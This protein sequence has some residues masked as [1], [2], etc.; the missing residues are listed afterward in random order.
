MG[1]GDLEDI[2]HN[3]GIRHNPAV[4][5][6]PGDDAA[7]YEIGG[8]RLIKTV[9]LITPVVNDPFTYGAISVCN[10]LSDVYAMGGRPFAALAIVGFSNCDYET[11]VL[12]E[13]LKG[14]L[15]ILDI[16][17]VSLVG[18]HCIDDRELKFGLSVTGVLSTNKILTVSGARAGDVLIITKPIGL[19]IITTALKGGKIADDDIA[20]AVKWMLTLNDEASV[21]ALNSGASA[22]TDVTGFGL[23]GHGYNMVKDSGLDLVINYPSVPVIERV[24]ELIDMGMVAAGAYNNLSYIKDK[25]DFSDSI[26]NEQKLVLTDP[27]TSGGLLIALSEES[28]CHFNG[29]FYA[30]IGRFQKGKGRIIVTGSNYH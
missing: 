28:L 16:A 14:A 5:I 2:V 26:S 10:S 21:R 12:K 30:P 27:Q 19:G 29:M 7:V 24:F 17:G 9:D 8:L 20:H 13:I 4:I 22:C 25:T 1:P 15:S 6:G 11:E 23:L 18:G 3:L